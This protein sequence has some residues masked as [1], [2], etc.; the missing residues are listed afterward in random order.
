MSEADAND[1]VTEQAGK[2]RVQD[3][4]LQG[5]GSHANDPATQQVSK[6]GRGT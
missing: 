6:E 2:E 1:P 3:F 4:G 5:S